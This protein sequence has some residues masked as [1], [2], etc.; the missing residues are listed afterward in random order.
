MKKAAYISLMMVL[1]AGALAAQEAPLQKE[2]REAAEGAAATSEAIPQS[3]AN[4][5]YYRRSVQLTEQAKAAYEDGDYDA[6]ALYAQ[7]AADY[8]HQS[9]EYVA[10]RLA[11]YAIARANSRYQWAK[12]VNAAT[13]Y[14]REFSEAGG[15][16]DHAVESRKGQQ[17]ASAK[18]YAD[19][20]VAVLANVK[21]AKGQAQPGAPKAPTQP[22]GPRDGTLPAQY[23]VRRWASTG[24][25]FSTISGWS[26]IYGDPY[27]WRKLYEANKDKIPNP[28]N[29]HLILPGT[30][31]D[32]PSIKG[33]ERSGMYDPKKKD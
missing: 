19:E 2:A 32:I 12:S 6:S 9:D 7:Q 21:D 26:F 10:M 30:V 31:L 14:P 8:A 29:P 16:L 23:T 28:S 5:E 11:D 22:A 1:A 3:I 17:W 15:L 25:C 33:E 27:Q 24:D 20:V 4:N 18:E 13:R